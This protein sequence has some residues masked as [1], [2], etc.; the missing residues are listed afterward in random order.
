VSA[1]PVVLAPLVWKPS[2]NRSSRNG[3]AI[4]HLL[5]HATAGAYGPSLR[6]L[7]TPTHYDAH[8]NVTSGPDASCHL[9]VREDGAEVSQLVKLH[10]K[11]WHAFPTWNLC[12]VG[13]EH[14]SLGAGFA[15]HAQL[16]ESARLFGW[17]CH[18]LGIPPVH[19]LHRPR[20]IVRHR[21][22]G[23]AGGGHR[24]GPSDAVWFHEYLPAV[25]HELARGGFRKEYAR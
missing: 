22:L 13:V 2:P 11:A 12:S 1:R 20:G 25:Q 5:W 6:W 19:G 18:H 4:T 15:T 16:L 9:M 23:A 17:L 8:G 7:C 10:E 14:A 21:D 3:H 24:D